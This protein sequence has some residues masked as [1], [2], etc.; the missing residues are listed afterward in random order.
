MPPKRGR[1]DNEAGEEIR[2]R[3]EEEKERARVASLM[4][5][6]SKKS[7]LQILAEELENMK[8][9]I[10]KGGFRKSKNKKINITKKTKKNKKKY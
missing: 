6:K 4:M 8:I 7:P 2:K 10:K 5:R 3:G 1:D 9:N